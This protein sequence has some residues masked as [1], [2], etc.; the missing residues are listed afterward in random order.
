MAL[1]IGIRNSI[2]LLSAIQATRPLTITLVGL[3]PTEHTSFSWTRFRTVSFPQ[4][5]SKA[6]IS[7]VAFLGPSEF[8]AACS[9]PTPFVHPLPISLYPRSESR[10]PGTPMH[11]RSGDPA[12]LP[13]GSLLRS[14][15]CCLGPSSLNRPHAPHS[16]QHSSISPMRLIRDALAVRPI[17]ASPRRPASGSVLSSI[18]LYQ[19]VVFF[20]PGKSVVCLHPVPSPTALTFDRL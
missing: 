12:A 17:P 19:H 2:S 15:L 10:E 16:R 8:V 18:V 4:S 13:Q 14:E 7:D 20:D 11:H 9:W 1:S 6:G 5:G 3:S